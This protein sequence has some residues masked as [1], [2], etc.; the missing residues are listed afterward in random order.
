LRCLCCL[1]NR[2]AKTLAQ[3]TEARQ[4]KPQ[5]HDPWS[6]RPDQSGDLAEIEVEGYDNPPVL[7]R[8]SEDF[9]IGQIG[10]PDIANVDA[11]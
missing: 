5:Q 10:Q 7:G 9:L 11:P 2:G 6:P 3:I 8:T 1:S 4:S